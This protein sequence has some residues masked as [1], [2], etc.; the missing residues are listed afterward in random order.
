[1]NNERRQ[2]QKENVCVWE[3]GRREG[4][5]AGGKTNSFPSSQSSGSCAWD[6]GSQGSVEK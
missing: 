6:L 1:M 5:V 4:G 3:V 2:K